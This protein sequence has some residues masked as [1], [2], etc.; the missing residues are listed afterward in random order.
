MG[1]DIN[2]IFIK[3]Q[4]LGELIV[5]SKPYL[6]MRDSE[7]RLRGNVD[8]ATALD[9]FA[10]HKNALESL[11]GSDDPDADAIRLHTESIRN[12]QAKLLDEPLYAAMNAARADFSAL[13]SQ[14]NQVLGFIVG[15]ETVSGESSCGSC[16]GSCEGCGGCGGR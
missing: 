7:A 4:E 11:F 16:G 15:G 5:N 3:T 14:V 2:E 10:A 6:D 13:I 8:T 9:E 12:V 1:S